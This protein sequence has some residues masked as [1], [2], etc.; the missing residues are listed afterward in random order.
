MEMAINVRAARLL[1]NNWPFQLYVQV[2]NGG[3]KQI[4]E[5]EKLYRHNPRY[6]YA[7]VHHYQ[8][9]KAFVYKA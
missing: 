1:Q 5:E 4:P 6:T 8:R 9:P 3:K 2:L 7:H